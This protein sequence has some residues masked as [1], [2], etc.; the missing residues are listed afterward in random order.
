MVISYNKE[1]FLSKTEVICKSVEFT[2]NQR[3]I[4]QSLPGIFRNLSGSL[5]NSGVESS[6]GMF[7]KY[8]IFFRIKNL[9]A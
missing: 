9:H 8:Q 6:L 7:R 2:Q 5:H 3:K 4:E 1:L